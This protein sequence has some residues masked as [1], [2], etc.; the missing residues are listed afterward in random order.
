MSTYYSGHMTAIRQLQFC[1][2]PCKTLVNCQKYSTCRWTTAVRRIKTGKFVI[3]KNLYS[4]EQVWCTINILHNRYMFAFCALLVEL[5][6]FRKVCL[7]AI[8][9][10]ILCTLKFSQGETFA[11]LG[12]H[13]Y[14]QPCF[15]ITQEPDLKFYG[16]IALMAENL[17]KM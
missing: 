2:N 10:S 13:I 5:K 14:R 4:N 12:F 17:Q 11:N 15:A 9:D 16:C 8:L 1:C 6:I 7:S 3:Y